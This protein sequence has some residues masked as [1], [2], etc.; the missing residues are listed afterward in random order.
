MAPTKLLSG[1]TI[2]KQHKQPRGSI[3][4]VVPLIL[5]TVKHYFNKATLLIF[6]FILF[7]HGV[8]PG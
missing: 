2:H 5:E 3:A 4:Y 1:G 6:D 8:T 7:I